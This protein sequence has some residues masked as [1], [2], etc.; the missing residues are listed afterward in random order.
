MLPNN[1]PQI[2]STLDKPRCGFWVQR[3]HRGVEVQYAGT[4]AEAVAIVDGWIREDA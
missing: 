2:Y 1:K 4:F 3:Y